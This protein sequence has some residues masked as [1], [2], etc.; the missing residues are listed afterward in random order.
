MKFQGRE[1]VWKQNKKTALLCVKS[2]KIQGLFGT[3]FR[4]V[5]NW[6]TLFVWTSVI[7]PLMWERENNGNIFIF[8]FNGLVKHKARTHSASSSLQPVILS[9][10]EAWRRLPPHF[11]PQCTQCECSISGSDSQTCDLERQ[12]CACA[13]R[14]GKCSCKVRHTLATMHTF[15]TPLFIHFSACQLY[16]QSEFSLDYR[17]V[18]ASAWITLAYE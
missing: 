14:T 6:T 2:V 15:F 18:S 3:Q 5:K 12:V 1:M 11:S 13:D 4:T 8:K 10:T 17:Q 16:L 7:F 9:I